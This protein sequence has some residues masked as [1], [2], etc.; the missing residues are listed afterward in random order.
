M[1]T[2]MYKCVCIYVYIH[3]YTHVNVYIYLYIQLCVYRHILP[4]DTRTKC[5]SAYTYMYMYMNMDIYQRKLIWSPTVLQATASRP[6]SR[7]P[8][9]QPPLLCWCVWICHVASRRVRHGALSTVACPKYASA[10]WR[11]YK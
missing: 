4:Q 1:Y 6:M 5:R 2:N 8:Q 9:A 10:S 7:L 11:T 3:I